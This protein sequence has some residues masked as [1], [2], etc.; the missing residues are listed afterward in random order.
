MHPKFIGQQSFAFPTSKHMESSWFK[1]IS[2]S[3]N[4]QK[5]YLQFKKKIMYTFFI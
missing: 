1:D 5:V 2:D 3:K 4:L